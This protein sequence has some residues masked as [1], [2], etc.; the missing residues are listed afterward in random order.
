MEQTIPTDFICF[1]NQLALESNGWIIDT[2]PYHLE[3]PNPFDDQTYVNSLSNNKHTFN[4]A[5]YYKQSFQHIP[6]LKPYEVV[7]WLDA[8]LEIIHDKVSEY[9]LQN[10]YEHKMIGWHHEWRRG[11]LMDEVKASIVED[12]YKHPFWNNQLQPFQ[13]VCKQYEV[14][15]KDGYRNEFFQSHTR[16]Q[17]PTREHFGVW[18]T[19]FVAFLQHEP[20]IA[21]FLELWYLQTLKF[22]TQD[23]VSFCYTCQK[24]N[25]VPFTLPNHEISGEHPHDNTYFYRK[26]EHG[27]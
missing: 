2:T 11:N 15:I 5:K 18:V 27:H 19:C 23:Q 6:R 25:L 9:V 12:K 8:T 26:H 21:R 24:T 4:I 7:V 3:N 14:Y 1:T 10:I 20:S 13:D 22:S 16:L 17:Q